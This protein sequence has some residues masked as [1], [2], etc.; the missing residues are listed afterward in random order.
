M[1]KHTITKFIGVFISLLVIWKINDIWLIGACTDQGGT[2]QYEQGKC[3]L[4]DGTLYITGY[5][6]LLVFV[7]AVVGLT[8]A[9]FVSKA[10]Q[11]VIK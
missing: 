4:E 10:L 7:Y 9:Y 6:T 11:K 5:E 3:V 2:F 1:N 8:V